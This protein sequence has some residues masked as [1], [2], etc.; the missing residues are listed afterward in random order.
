MPQYNRTVLNI[1]DLP[2][3]SASN[4]FL[5]LDELFEQSLDLEYFKSNIEN[6]TTQEQNYICIYAKV[7][8]NTEKKG[9]L[10]SKIIELEKN[11]TLEEVYHDINTITENSKRL[12]KYID[13]VK[14]KTLKRQ[15]ALIKERKLSVDFSKEIS[16][17]SNSFRL[18][19]YSKNKKIKYSENPKLVEKFLSKEIIELN[20]AQGRDPEINIASDFFIEFRN[21]FYNVLDGVLDREHSTKIFYNSFLFDG[22]FMETRFLNI[23]FEN[24]QIIHNSFYKIFNRYNELQTKLIEDILTEDE[25]VKNMS[26]I[27][28]KFIRKITKTNES[29]NVDFMKIM[30]NAFPQIRDTYTIYRK[31]N[32]HITLISYLTTKSRNIR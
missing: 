9:F 29:T 8:F 30:Y 24:S 7:Y 1:T 11:F 22:N 16:I 20:L 18:P 32:P 21:F 31:R 2:P 14:S 27:R 12:L 25:N 3:K 4:V 19:L 6:H 17:T 28:R 26:T 10:Q 23:E 15:N 5:F 13:Q